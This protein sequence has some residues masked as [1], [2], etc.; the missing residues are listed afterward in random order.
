M[1]RARYARFANRH[2]AAAHATRRV[3]VG[4]QAEADLPAAGQLDIDLR[5][6]L[7]VEQ[8]AMLDPVAAV[9]AEAHAQGVEAVLGAGMPGAGERQRVDHPAGADRGR[10]HYLEFV[11]EEAEIEG[12]IMRDQRQI[13]DELE[14]ILGRSA[15]QRLVRQEDVA[16][17]V[18]CF[19]FG[20]HRPF[21]IEISVE[22]AAGFDPVENLDAADFDHPVAAGRV[23]P[24]VSVSKTIS[25]TSESIDLRRVPD[26][27]EYRATWRFS[28]G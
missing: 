11:I 17:P 24:V 20:R 28:C 3:G 1:M 10:P 6:Q 14:Q 16:Q 13:L 22:V 25:R 18:D 15:K 7:R 8:G 2:R 26:K 9:D 27:Q 5:E 19:G 23:E 12:R 4:D 21:G